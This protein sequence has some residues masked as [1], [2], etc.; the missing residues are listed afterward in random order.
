M[1]RKIPWP[2][3]SYPGLFWWILFWG[4]DTKP[5]CGDC[6]IW[7][8]LHR[9]RHSGPLCIYTSLV[10]HLQATA[11]ELV[12]CMADLAP[13]RNQ[14]PSAWHSPRREVWL[15][16]DHQPRRFLSIRHSLQRHRRQVVA[17]VRRHTWVKILSVLAH[18]SNRYPPSIYFNWGFLLSQKPTFLPEDQFD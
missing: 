14:M 2:S 17:V 5:A 18:W 3:V 16:I 12:T 6:V 7:K 15:T 9:Q 10:W 4:E 8:P 13:M 11:T 1:W